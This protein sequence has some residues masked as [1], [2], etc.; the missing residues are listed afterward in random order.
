M[1][2]PGMNSGSSTSSRIARG[3]RIS[4]TAIAASSASTGVTVAAITAMR[5][6]VRIAPRRTPLSP[7]AAYH[8]T[9]AAVP[10]ALRSVNEKTNG[11][12]SGR[13]RKPRTRPT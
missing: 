5:S 13:Y 2:I 4:R 9:V 10:A 11:G 8:L 12:T 1:L 6:D 3:A 7:S